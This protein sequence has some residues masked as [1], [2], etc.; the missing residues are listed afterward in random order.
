MSAN[1]HKTAK[2]GSG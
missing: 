1:E 2:Q